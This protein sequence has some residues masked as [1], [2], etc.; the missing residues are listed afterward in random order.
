MMY[1]PRKRKGDTRSLSF[2]DFFGRTRDDGGNGRRSR[3]ADALSIS[4]RDYEALKAKAD[5]YDALKEQYDAVLEKH[6]GLMERHKQVKDWNDR[7]LK[8]LDDMKDDS[9]KF[10]ELKEEREKFL[11][12]LLEVRADFDNYRKRQERENSRY[13]SYVLEG[14]L[15][16]LVRHYDDLVRALNLMK[17]TEG[18]EGIRKGF[19]LVVNNYKKL[20]EEE[21]VRP[22]EAE[23]KKFD[24]YNHEA[25]LVEECRDDLPENTI[26]EVLD[27]GYF[28][29]EKVLRPAKVKISKRSKEFPLTEIKVGNKNKDKN[30]ILNEN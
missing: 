11:R 17:R 14:L 3:S 16:K 21:G 10:K 13:K 23:G 27:E 1:E 22:M 7:M 5:Q 18:M 8:E 9:R 6:E 15:K 26:T 29:K 30:K 4:R 2:E 19:E 20:L 24:P 28:L 12:S 25:L